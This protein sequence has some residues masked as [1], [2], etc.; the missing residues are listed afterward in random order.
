MDNQEADKII[1][2]NPSMNDKE[3]DLFR[4]I[5]HRYIR[6]FSE[7]LNRFNLY[8]YKYF[9]DDLNHRM[10]DK[11]EVMQVKD[12]DDLELKVKNGLREIEEFRFLIPNFHQLF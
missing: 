1:L 4:T 7:L 2:F 6:S 10:Q 11:I 9:Y 3:R 12:N 8:T 5:E